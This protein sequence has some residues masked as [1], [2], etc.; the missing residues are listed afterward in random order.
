MLYIGRSLILT[1]V[2]RS[3]LLVALVAGLCCGPAAADHLTPEKACPSWMDNCEAP[4]GIPA[5]EAHI[6]WGCSISPHEGVFCRDALDR[7]VRD[8]EM[9]H[10]NGCGPS[11]LL[12]EFENNTFRIPRCKG[13]LSFAAEYAR[14]GGSLPAANETR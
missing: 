11:P 2:N 9:L 6:P 14:Y 4:Q 3:H 7:A 10:P 5:S 13:A 1:I 12:N 8:P